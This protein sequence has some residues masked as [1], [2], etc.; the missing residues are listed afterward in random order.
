MR[1]GLF[2]TR[3]IN[4]TEHFIPLEIEELRRRGHIVEHFWLK[5][6]WPTLREAKRLDFA[7]YHFVPTALFFRNIYVPY[8]VL[9]TANDCFPDE[10]RALK[11][12]IDHPY[13]RFLGYQ[14]FFHK[15][16]YSEWGIESPTVHIPHCVRTHLFKRTHLPSDKVIA[17]GRLIDRKALHLLSS[18]DNL[19]IFGDGPLKEEL[20]KQLPKAEF[21][22]YLDG[23]QLK[24]LMEES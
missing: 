7:V 8:C 10:G 1:I 5:G 19:I 12:A 11:Q 18:V 2:N 24:Q 16:K 6:R 23:N 22:G 4:Q 21:T 3:G 20:Q 14:S 9:P 13:F 17:G 15:H